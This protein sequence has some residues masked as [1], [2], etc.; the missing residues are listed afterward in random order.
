[1]RIFISH[2]MKNKEVVLKFAEF[3]ESVSSEIEVFCSSENGSIIVGKD[4][5]KTIFEELNTGNLFI[6]IISREY[7]ESRFC[8]IELGVAYSYLFQKYEKNGE[9]Y[10]FPF[11]LHPVTKGQALSGTPMRNIQTGEMDDENDIKSFLEYLTIERGIHIGAGVNRKLHSFKTELA[12]ILL[13]NQNILEM[14]RIGTY[15]DD[16]I[17]YMHKEDIVGYSIKDNA[18][19]VNYNMN[20]YER[21]DMR[22]PNFI[23][24][25]LRYPD[26]ID[27]GRYLDFNDAAEMSFVLTSFTNSLNRILIEF[28]Y[29]DSNRIL[30]TI[31]LSVVHGENKLRIPLKEMYSKALSQISEICFVIHPEDIVEEE[32]MFKIS[33]ILI[34]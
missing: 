3:L 23:S 19:V 32:G 5:I 14:A 20:P 28:K 22:L 4:F 12:H 8:M 9:D 17:D 27:L 25:A 29:S 15:F 7:Y 16:N 31:Q 21:K 13:K 11:A 33:D 6:P 1:M 30:E 26:K 24:V 18:L 2:A 34:H 10:I